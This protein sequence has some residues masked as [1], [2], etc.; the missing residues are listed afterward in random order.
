[1]RTLILGD[2]GTGKTLLTKRL[3]REALEKT[4]GMVTVLDFAPPAKVISSSYVEEI[5]KVPA[6]YMLG[7]GWLALRNL[8]P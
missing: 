3:L 1:M 7:G 5:K 8:G 4:D 6:Q 2:V